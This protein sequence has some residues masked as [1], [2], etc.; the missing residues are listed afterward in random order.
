MFLL[1]IIVR[2]RELY[3]VLFEIYIKLQNIQLINTKPTFI[4]MRLKF[5]LKISKLSNTVTQLSIYNFIEIF[6]V[7]F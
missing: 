2:R 5:K 3:S 6:P 1:K 4:N 7:K